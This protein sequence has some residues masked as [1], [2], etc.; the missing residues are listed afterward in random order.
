MKRQGQERGLG[1]LTFISSVKAKA[2]SKAQAERDSSTHKPA[3]PSSLPFPLIP[4]PPHSARGVYAPY[5][6]LHTVP[7]LIL[8]AI[9]S[10]RATSEVCT[11]PPSP[12]FVSLARAICG[13]AGQRR[14]AERGGR[15]GEERTAVSSSPSLNRSTVRIGPNVSA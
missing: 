8:F 11:P 4:N 2:V 6:L 5:V 13:R 10:A 12:N 15:R 9:L 1:G 3:L 7:C 14:S